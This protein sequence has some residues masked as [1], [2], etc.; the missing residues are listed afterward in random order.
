ML[1]CNVYA[2]IHLLNTKTNMQEPNHEAFPGHVPEQTP[3]EQLGLPT[4]VVIQRT[5]SD[6]DKGWVVDGFRENYPHPDTGELITAVKLSKYDT[7]TGITYERAVSLSDLQVWNKP[8]EE[9]TIPREQPPM[10]VTP[11]T[12]STGESIEVAREVGQV[13]VEESGV[14]EPVVDIQGPSDKSAVE[15]AHF[16][17]E[18]ESTPDLGE[19]QAQA[20]KA[21]QE[22]WGLPESQTLEAGVEHA[23]TMLDEQMQKLDI[24]SGLLSQLDGVG[25]GL[26]RQIAESMG[27][28]RNLVTGSTR[29]ELERL[30]FGREF[31]TLLD[32]TNGDQFLPAPIRNKLGEFGRNLRGMQQSFSA[33]NS[34]GPNFLDM[35]AADTLSRQWRALPEVTRQV[36]LARQQVEEMRT[37]LVGYRESSEVNSEKSEFRN[38]QVENWSKELAGEVTPERLEEITS[39]MQA[40]VALEAG[41]VDD[42]N[43]PSRWFGD[44]VINNWPKSNRESTHITGKEPATIGSQRY[45]AELMADMLTG[46]YN[47]QAGN[48]PLPIEVSGDEDAP[49][50]EKVDSG[51]HRAAALAMLYGQDWQKTAKKLGIKIEKS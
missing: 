34:R 45:V 9:D 19:K 39:E 25:N 22:I 14:V 11:E 43:S 42:P 10:P 48:S 2:N 16:K 21:L 38:E 18:P 30:L 49:V 7:E 3:A 5:S 24:A 33:M 20:I 40:A 35:G 8:P 4:S 15:Q 47:V 26:Q 31:S 36:V 41:M 51:F 17:T 29:Q 13:A 1:F 28:S 46:R 50:H 44:R 12:K 6:T 37:N 23:T 32:L 27:E